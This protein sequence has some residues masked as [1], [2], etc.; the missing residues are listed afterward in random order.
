MMEV[1]GTVIA[2][3]RDYKHVVIDKTR[4][5]REAVYFRKGHGPRVRIHE[6]I[7]SPEFDQRYY[8]LLRL[9]AAG[10]LKPARQS[11]A[12]VGTLRWLCELYLASPAFKELAPTTQ[13]VRRTRIDDMCAE[14]IAPGADEVYGDFPLAG[15]TVPSRTSFGPRHVAFLRDRKRE[16]P[17]A[18]NERVKVLRAVFNWALD[19]E[20]AIEGVTSNPARDVKSLRPKREGGFPPWTAEDIE[21]FEDRHPRG[22]KARLVL[23]LFI[24]TG[25]RI[26]DAISL[27][28]QYVDA[29]NRLTFTT[30][31][32][33]SNKSP[34]TVSLPV[35]GE[36]AKAIAAGPVGDMI[37]LVTHLGRPY[38][39]KGLANFLKRQCR[40]AGLPER[41]SAHGLRKAAAERAAEHGATAFELMAMFGWLDHKT[42]A[43]YVRMANRKKLAANAPTLLAR[44]D[45]EQESRTFNPAPP[46]VREKAVKN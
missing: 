7:G 8:E 15:F 25:V 39:V 11:T 18:A 1:N 41:R 42:A 43:H 29:D 10:G 2:V 14:P 33:R 31:K 9:S 17:E 5:G 22:T 30:F 6:P 35:E 38:T 26:S 46:Q 32:S 40:M 3:R 28:R 23:D 45:R 16:T 21:K 19:P 44:P 4:H 37:Y 34:V 27:G 24:Y 13:R 36:L 12:R 20:N